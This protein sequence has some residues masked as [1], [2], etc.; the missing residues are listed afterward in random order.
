[1]DI[2]TDEELD[3]EY[4]ELWMQLP[5]S[6]RDAYEA[7]WS[8]VPELRAKKQGEWAAYRGPELLRIGRSKTEVG[9]WCRAQGLSLED[10]IVLFIERKCHE[11]TVE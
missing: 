8:A 1:M 4:Q 10:F 11:P 5:K 2:K 9:Q 6:T 3:A 7:M